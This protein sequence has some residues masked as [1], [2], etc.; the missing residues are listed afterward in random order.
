ML[1]DL[2]ESFQFTIKAEQ[3]VPSKFYQYNIKSFNLEIN[4]SFVWDSSE[5]LEVALKPLINKFIS[6][7]SNGSKLEQK[8][9]YNDE[10]LK[11]FIVN[12][13]LLLT[14]EEKLDSVLEYISRATAYD[15]QIIA[16]KTPNKFSIAKMYFNNLTEWEFYIN[17]AREQQYIKKI[18]KG[19]TSGE[20]PTSPPLDKYSLTISGLTRLIA[21]NVRKASRICFVAMAF[22]DKMFDI[23]DKAIDPATRL[24]GF[25]PYIVAKVHT[26]SDETINDAILA[27]I[28]KAR[29]TIADFTHHRSGVYFEAGYALGRGQKVIYTC[30]EDE[31]VNAHFDIRNYQHIVWKDANDFKIKLISK[32]EAFIIE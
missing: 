14:P 12:N 28:K 20:Q 23:F 4:L 9:E 19:M 7:I 24:C 21:I 22:D 16:I 30:R 32:I 13:Y 25:E 18:P 11:E 5:K 17:Y 2:F 27:G 31:M 1:K 8:T 26:E 15:G 29:F 6:V 10:K 3:I